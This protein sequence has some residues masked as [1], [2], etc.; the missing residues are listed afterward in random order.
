MNASP[1]IKILT[2]TA[3]AWMLANSV[4]AQVSAG[5]NRAEVQSEAIAAAHAPNQNVTRGSRGAEPFSSVADRAAVRQQAIE[6]ARAPNQNVTRGSRGADPFT[7]TAD[8]ATV[9]AQAEAAATAPDQNVTSGSRV[10]SKVVS[11]MPNS[12]QVRADAQG[13][14]RQ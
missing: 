4:H 9:R 12:A 14:A 8:P 13:S 10:N 1:I 3:I 2:T 7:S 6:T 5:R 11:T